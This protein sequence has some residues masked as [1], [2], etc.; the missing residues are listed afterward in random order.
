MS[1]A[2]AV[3]LEPHLCFL[4]L[5]VFCGVVMFMVGKIVRDVHDVEFRYSY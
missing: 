2:G 5:C 3:A 4:G 1:G